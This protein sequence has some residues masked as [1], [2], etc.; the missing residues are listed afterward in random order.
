MKQTLSIFAALMLL[1]CGP[2]PPKVIH[3]T[4]PN[5]DPYVPAER[6]QPNPNAIAEYSKPIAGDL[7]GFV[8]AVKAF[9]TK[10]TAVFKL[11]MQY[12]VLHV[13][14]SFAVTLMYGMP[15]I[16]IQPDSTKTYGCFV[17]MTDSVQGFLP[18]RH[19]Y[20]QDEQLKIKTIAKVAVRTRKVVAD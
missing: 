1:A 20:V 9:E 16:T 18:M 11:D 4:A 14:D 8:F 5:T 19:I 13:V 7:N 6:T 3:V 17:G 10:R 2:E 12:K 15:R